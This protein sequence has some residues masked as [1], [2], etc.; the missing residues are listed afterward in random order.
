MASKRDYYEVLGVGKEA[1]LEE[2]KRAYRKLA[3][4]YHP[5]R[6]VGDK[7]AEE[8]FKE[9]AEAYDVLHDHEKR[10]RYDRYGHAGLN[11]LGG[12]NFNDAGSIFDLFGDIF[13]DFFGQ[14]R[15][16]RSGPQG[17]RDL[18]VSLEI[19]LIEAARGTR[20]SITIPREENCP[21][22]AGQGYR[23]GTKP[24]NCRRC[25]GQGV[26]LIN[27]GF[28]RMQ[29]TCSGCGGRGIIITDPCPTCHGGGRIEARRTLEIDV[30][31][32]VDTGTRIRISGE[33]EAGSPRAPRGDLYCL[34]RVREHPFFQRDGN[35]LVCQ[36]PITFSQAA[37]GGEIDVPTLDGAIK[38]A[39]KRGMQSGEVVR[40][41][42]RG[43]PNVR[44]GR[45]GDLLVQVVVET[46]RNLTKRQEELLRELAELDKSHVSAQRK[47]FL[48]KLRD[49]FTAEPARD[50]AELKN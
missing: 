11:G 9:A 17:G 28:F 2:I 37:L 48:E 7:E 23:K 25:G 4:Q 50:A 35:H 32:G 22:C 47:S 10:Q 39:I 45:T 19:D 3:M 5:D 20:K 18:Q 14:Q 34:L 16:G 33:G 46:P 15:G 38:H 29:Q 44:G 49:F 21:D 26:V 24:A 6:N 8:K 42:G 13:G 41:A 36:V 1:D 27:Q 43:M 12:P 31:P 40:I 30:P